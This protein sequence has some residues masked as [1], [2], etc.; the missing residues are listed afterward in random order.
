MHKVYRDYCIKVLNETGYKI[1]NVHSNQGGEF[2]GANFMAVLEELDQTW[3]VSTSHEPRQNAFVERLIGTATSLARTAMICSNCPLFLWWHARQYALETMRA[4]PMGDAEYS[5]HELIY[6]E[7]ADAR[8]F[9]P[10]GCWAQTY[11]MS[12][13]LPDPKWSVAGEEG[14]FVGTALYAN[15]RGFAIYIPKTKK[16]VFTVSARFDQLRFPYRNSGRLTP[17]YFRED[18]NHPTDTLVVWP[19]TDAPL[20]DVE[21]LFIPLSAREE[22]ELLDSKAEH[23]V[24]DVKAEEHATT[25]PVQKESV[26]EAEAG[27]VTRS[28]TSACQKAAVSFKR[29]PEQWELDIVREQL[30]G[31]SQV[32]FTDDLV[33]SDGRDAT[34]L[35]GRS[36]KQVI[37]GEVREGFVEDFV[38]DEQMRLVLF[39]VHFPSEGMGQPYRDLVRYEELQRTL[40]PELE[41]NVIDTEMSSELFTEVTIT[42]PDIIPT[43]AIMLQRSEEHTSEL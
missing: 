36:I 5:P 11:M 9:Y 4:I 6:Q 37:D 25:D 2:T 23:D 16:I 20:H 22:T 1:K 13:L 28:K 7:Q 27:P 31:N 12:N 19:G 33:L 14:I 26:V 35:V 42:G 32:D 8:L 10:F 41:A 21:R 39:G 43:R 3:S 40:V 34:D 30:G 18:H 38:V 29:V 24:L 15:Q 17:A